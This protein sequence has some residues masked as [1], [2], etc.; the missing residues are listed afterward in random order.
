M[1]LMRP[2]DALLFYLKQQ[3]KNPELHTQIQTLTEFEQI[4]E[5]K[6]G[7]KMS[8]LRDEIDKLKKQARE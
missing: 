8:I 2:S 4:L 3:I 7:M 1:R 5:K 6:S